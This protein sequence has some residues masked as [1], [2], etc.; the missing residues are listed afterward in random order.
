MTTEAATQE[1]PPRVDARSAFIARHTLTPAQDVDPPPEAP[2]AEA[3]PEV[4][5][6]VAH[7]ARIAAEKE[8]AAQRL[9]ARQEEAARRMA[10]VS[11]QRQE[12][13]PPTSPAIQPKDLEA[14][15]LAALERLG[16]DPQR[17]YSALTRSSLNPTAAAAERAA[18]A[19]LEE[20]RQAREETARLRAEQEQATQS[21]SIRAARA[22]ITEAL[23]NAEKYPNAAALEPGD[24]VAFALEQWEMFKAEE[25]AEGRQPLYDEDLIAIRV[26]DRVSGLASKF[27]P[28][29]KASPKI[30]E[31]TQVEAPKHSAPQ[32][33]WS[34]KD[35]RARFIKKYG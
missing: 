7:A 16:V 33:G 9:R 18:A 25:I 31:T 17:V 26:E 15:P 14:D 28:K 6:D 20:A 24:R 22:A 19:A 10:A 21:A 12:P 8:A 1:Q 23:G 30:V 35:H 11:Q 34:E 29:A 4:D 32:Q 13:P 27:R 2:P 5:P 3:P